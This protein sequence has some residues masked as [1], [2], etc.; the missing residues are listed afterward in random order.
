[1]PLFDDSRNYYRE[2]VA[3][4]VRYGYLRSNPRGALAE[5]ALALSIEA[6][7]ARKDPRAADYAR[8]YLARY[9]EG[10]FR[11]L[12]QRVAAR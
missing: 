11:S 12:A 4:G 1:M 7:M 8:R 6:A 5:D 2:D 3:A 10:R 9:P